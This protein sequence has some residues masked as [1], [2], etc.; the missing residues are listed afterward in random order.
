[1]KFARLAVAVLASVI[2]VPAMADELV[3]R[4]AFGYVGPFERLKTGYEAASGDKIRLASGDEAADL[5]I[6]PKQ[7]I[8]AMVKEG[9]VNAAGL[10]D[11][12]E[13]RVGLAVKAG[14]PKP[15]ISTPEKLKAVLLGAKSVGVS[16]FLSGQIVTG[17]L[18]PK[19]GIADQMKAKTVTVATGSVGEAVAKGDA[20]MGFQ[21]MSELVPVQGIAIVGR[22]P[23][24]VQ[25][26][27]VLTAGISKAA[28]SKAA[29]QRFIAY[30]KSPAAAA[31][32]KAM[33][34]DAAK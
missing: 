2:A 32:H 31:A 15:D 3:V 21:Q 30:T 18:F 27:T 10:T 28:K 9:K 12:A 34:L 22:V 17:E 14:M 24:S 29:A 33:D 25:R 13:M 1:M 8:E 6:Q 20:E 16:R 26:V 19:L 11:I 4:A 7:Q 23:E 5:V